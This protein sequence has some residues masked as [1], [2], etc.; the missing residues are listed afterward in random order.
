MPRPT[1][2]PRLYLRP[3]AEQRRAR[4]C[5]V[6]RDGRREISTGCG[7]DQQREAERALASHIASKLALPPADPD[8]RQDPTRVLIREVLSLYAAERAPELAV[9]QASMDGWIAH[10]SVWWGDS[11]L[12]HVRRSTCK[13]YVADRTRETALVGGR[14]TS[15]PVSDQTARRELEVLSAAIGYWDAEDRLLYRPPVWLPPKAETRRNALSRAEVAALLKAT[16]GWR[17]EP[18]GGWTRLGASA[19]ANRAHLRRFLLIALYTGSR[20]SVVTS[21]SWNRSMTCAWVDLAK[22]LLYRRGTAERDIANKSRPPAKLPP[23]LLAHM[24]RWRR[25]D[26]QIHGDDA[27]KVIHHGDQGVSGVRKGFTA[28]V[29]DA[30]L[31][32]AVTPHW[33]R[34]TA[35]TLLMEANVDIWLAASY[36]G[37]SAITLERHYAHHRTD[38]Q[39]VARRAL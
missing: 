11:A 14:R 30:G 12:S 3:A 18:S 9:D 37:V 1:K 25:H 27:D 6:I 2:G 7:P 13:A 29:A 19:I 21:L 20:T 5:Y 33:V 16:L 34:H 17:L 35:A 32:E 31:P 38:F 22:G 36:L 28:C 10:L 24:R 4:P 8:R 23:R 39:G 26:V 15:R